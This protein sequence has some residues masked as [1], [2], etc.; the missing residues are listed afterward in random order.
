MLLNR[1]FHTIS[2]FSIVFLASGCAPSGSQV[3]SYRAEKPLESRYP[4]RRYIVGHGCASVTDNSE[5]DRHAADQAARAEVAKQIRV[6][7]V[8]VVEDMQKEEMRDDKIQETY[9]I[10]IR[11]RAVVESTLTGVKIVK[12]ELDKER[13]LQCSVAVLDK[14][15]VARGIYEEAA[16]TRVEVQEYLKNADAARV[17]G[18]LAEPLRYYTL[19][20]LSL[21]Q[22]TV[23]AKLL[24]DIGY[25]SPQLPSRVEIGN[26]WIHELQQIRLEQNQGEG[27][28]A[29]P[30]RPLDVPLIVSAVIMGGSPVANLPLK[31][32]RSPDNCDMQI[33]TRTDSQGRAAFRVFRAVSTG[34][35]LEEIAI[36]IDWETLLQI[37]AEPEAPWKL[38]DAREVVFTYRVPVPAE[39]RVGVAVY[40]YGTGRPLNASPVQ[41]ALLEGLQLAG[42]KTL[43][44]FSMPGTMSEYFKKKPSRADACRRLAGKL[45]ILLLGEVSIAF[46][47]TIQGLDIY[48]ARGNMQGISIAEGRVMTTMDIDAKGRG[49]DDKERAAR[50]AIGKL[51]KK[52]RHTIGPALE[53]SLD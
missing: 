6:K 30:G 4:S 50:D 22:M 52:L 17:K 2:I 26:K 10:T 46:S 36:G 48:R 19:A 31:V 15:A 43:D 34:K 44:L 33:R 16:K 38:W 5:R 25:D 28:R 8:Q 21:N 23:K 37:E 7:V 40:E 18:I 49:V 45:D 39:Y 20:V 32:L 41:A 53:K 27:Q 51:S 12:R 9:T 42:F 47:S 11:T 14:E 13:A 3:Q 35:A 1:I 29:S 24:A